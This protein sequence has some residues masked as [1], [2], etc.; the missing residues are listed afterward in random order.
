MVLLKKETSIDSKILPFTHWWES[1]RREKHNGY[2]EKINSILYGFQRWK[3]TPLYANFMFPRFYQHRMLD[4]QIYQ[5]LQKLG[6]YTEEEVVQYS[7]IVPGIRKDLKKAFGTPIPGIGLAVG[8]G[9]FNWMFKARF[10]LVHVVLVSL[11]PAISQI[12]YNKWNIE[13]KH[14]ALKFLDWNVENRKAKT[15]L[16]GAVK[17]INQENLAAFKAALPNKTLIDAYKDY[18]AYLA[19]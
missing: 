4:L 6:D 5:D 10:N 1:I 14:E 16:E 18:L 11:T 15:L 7:Q 13:P 9:V 8:A 12:I 17:D 3:Q 19:K 2:E